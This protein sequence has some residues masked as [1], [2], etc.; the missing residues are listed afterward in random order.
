MADTAR[1][2]DLA[3]EFD[4]GTSPE[5]IHRAML[6]DMNAEFE[7]QTPKTPSRS[8]MFDASLEFSPDA[9]ITAMVPTNATSVDNRAPNKGDNLPGTTLPAESA[10]IPFASNTREVFVFVLNAQLK[11]RFINAAGTAEDQITLEQDTLTIFNGEYRGFTVQDGDAGTST[12]RVFGRW[13]Q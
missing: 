1:L 8:L 13:R 2:Y 7:G 11:I 10:E 12:Y 6:F 3:M 4:D 9:V 5:A